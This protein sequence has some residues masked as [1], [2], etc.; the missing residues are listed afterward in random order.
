MEQFAYFV[1]K[2]KETRKGQGRFWITVLLFIEQ[3]LP[4]RIATPTTMSYDDRRQRGRTD[5]NRE[6]CRFR[7]GNAD[8]QPAPHDAQSRWGADRQIGQL[9]RE[10]GFLDGCVVVSRL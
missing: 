1:E 10:V 6:A 2:M 8:K 4:I 5:Q 9:R 7:P 3:R